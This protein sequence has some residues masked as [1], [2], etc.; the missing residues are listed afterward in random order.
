MI[1]EIKGVQFVNKGAEL[2]LHAVLQQL[3]QRFPN[4]QIV[5]KDN[6]N[7]P[8]LK[9]I[10]VGAYQKLE[11][12]KNVYDF[13]ELFYKLPKKLRN[14][15][16]KWGAVS[17]ADI[18]VILD[19]SGFSYG[20]QWS[21]IILAQV[22]KEAKRMKSK[23]KHY[24]F[25]PQALGPFS[26][27]EQKKWAKIA[28]E[29]ASLV[30]ARE[31]DSFG[32]VKSLV[33]KSDNIVCYPDFT[34]LVVGT[35]P[36]KFKAN[37]KRWFAVIPNSK[38]L[39]KR[40]ANLAWQT[41]YI[42]TFAAIIEEATRQ[43]L[44]PFLLNHEGEEDQVLCEQINGKLTQPVEILQEE[45]PLNVKGIIGSSEAILCSRYHGCVSALSQGIP[46]LG[47]SWSH[48]Y[49]KL[50]EEYG[51]SEYL[52]TPHGEEDKLKEHLHQVLS[53][54]EVITK[55]LLSNAKIYKQKSKAMWDKVEEVI[56]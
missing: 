7:S 33:G 46:C 54:K 47:T 45:D 37:D 39:S 21:A 5:L 10:S 20:D 23:G 36:E 3:E 4:A 15:L 55:T 42:N 29:N 27:A 24:V 11:L 44:T 32:H 49:E 2:M 50:F 30:A 19:A 26:Q 40:N 48:K 56:S 6:I 52:V 1:I 43:G 13:G 34:N 17:E 38:M 9:R 25:M 12:K 18:D 16:L 14:W 31:K 53:D 35:V 41:H 51:V 22:A 8:Y 28:F